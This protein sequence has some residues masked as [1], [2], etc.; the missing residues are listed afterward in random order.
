MNTIP[1][2]DS[3]LDVFTILAVALIAAVPSWLA[4]RNHRSIKEISGKTETIIGQVQNWHTGPP[5]RAD[6]D[7]A[8]AAIEALAQDISGLRADLHEERK[9]RTAQV[10]DLRS[11]VDRMRRRP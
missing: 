2:P 11:D 6:L 1:N 4:A 7:R 9:S 5:L 8:I 10:E 3:F